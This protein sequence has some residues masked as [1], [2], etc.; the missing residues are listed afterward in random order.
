[1]VEVIT[2]PEVVERFKKDY[3]SLL[4]RVRE[5]NDKIIA[6][7]LRVMDFED[8]PVFDASMDKIQ[9]AINKLQEL[10]LLL[11]CIE[12]V[13]YGQGDCLYIMSNRT[14]VRKCRMFEKTPNGQTVETSCWA[15]PSAIHYWQQEWSEFTRVLEESKN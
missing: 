1:M 15:C 6:A 11:E 8:G 9:T 3:P 2:P 7:Y 12:E 14:K 13:L 10:C 4:L 5:G